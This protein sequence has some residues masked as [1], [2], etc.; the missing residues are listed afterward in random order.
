MTNLAGIKM[1]LS[2]SGLLL[3]ILFPCSAW[4]PLRWLLH[5][6]H[7]RVKRQFCVLEVSCPNIRCSVQDSS[8]KTAGASGIEEQCWQLEHGCGNLAATCCADTFRFVNECLQASSMMHGLVS[9]PPALRLL[10]SSSRMRAMESQNEK[11]RDRE[12]RK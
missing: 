1:F 10:P 9:S 5:S 3:G 2:P 7:K 12:E 4:P 6:K 11:E 8:I